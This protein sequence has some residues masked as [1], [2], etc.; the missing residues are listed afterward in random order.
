LKPGKER[1]SKHLVNDLL[2]VVRQEPALHGTALVAITGCEDDDRDG[3]D[4]L[5]LLLEE[6]GNQVHVTYGGM[7]TAAEFPKKRRKSLFATRGVDSITASRCAAARR[8]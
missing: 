4:S 3:A 6:L 2:D 1:F 7:P 5:G 8:C